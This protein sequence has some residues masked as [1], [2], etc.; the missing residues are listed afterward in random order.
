MKSKTAIGKYGLAQARWAGLGPY[1]AMFPTDFAD[2]VV[3]K[4]SQIGDTVIDP[5]AG[6]GTAIFSAAVHRRHAIGIDINP[7]G[8]VYGKAKIEPGTKQDV[9]DRLQFIQDLSPRYAQESE[10]L[11]P[12]FHIAYHGR[13]RKFLVAARENLDW[14]HTPEDRTLMAMILVSLHGKSKAALSNHMRQT[15]AMAPDYCIRW[16]KERGLRPPDICP[17]DFLTKRIDWRYAK[18]IPQVARSSFY[19]D[20]STR[21]L[22]ELC[23]EVETERQAKAKLLLTSPPYH[24]VTNYY[25]DQW[26]RLWLLGSPPQPTGVRKT[27]GGKFSNL[28]NYQTLLQSVFNLTRPLLDDDAVIYV[29]TGN[30]R[31]TLETT[32]ATL[33]SAFPN[34]A[35]HQKLRPIRE[36]R[37]TRPYSRGGAPRS[38]TCEVDV[39]LTPN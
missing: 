35:V 21:K 23:K 4:Y 37:K 32:I 38:P 9:I 34:K 2:A 11:P 7:L 36:E 3:R 16:W 15:T 33:Q 13:V 28:T 29:R 10:E 1:Y 18:G 17:V 22:P 24:N 6:R 31:T 20:D 26:I 39:I 30:Q 8:Y 5:F 19:L 12:F 25:Y 14:R 27:F